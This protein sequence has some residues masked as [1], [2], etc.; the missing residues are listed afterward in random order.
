MSSGNCTT[1]YTRLELAIDEEM[2]L[3]ELALVRNGVLR[4]ALALLARD[5]ADALAQL[6]GY[7]RD[8]LPDAGMVL[9][10][11]AV[12]QASEE[13]EREAGSGR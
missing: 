3:R 9:M 4:R 2:I 10:L 7:A 11:C 6:R 8:P 12:M 1:E 13:R 5:Q